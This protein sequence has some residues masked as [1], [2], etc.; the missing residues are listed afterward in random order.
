MLN[1][2]GIEPLGLFQLSIIGVPATI[3]VIIW[4]YAVGY[5]WLPDHGSQKHEKNNS[6]KS[7]QFDL[8]VPPHAGIVGKTIENAGLRE[9]KNAFLIHIQRQGN[10]IGPVGPNWPIA[11]GDILSF[12]GE[13]KAVNQ[14]A[15]AKSLKMAVPEQTDK[16]TALP[17]YEG[18][19]A[20]TSDMVGRSLKD[21]SFR[22]RIGGVVLAIQ[23]PEGHLRGALGSIPL[24][25]GDLLLIEAGQTFQYDQLVNSSHFYTISRKGVRHKVNKKQQAI[26]F[27][28]LLAMIVIA[29]SGVLPLVSV[30]LVAALLVLLNGNI[31]MSQLLNAVQLPILLVIAAA[32]GIGQAVEVSGMADMIAHALLSVSSVLGP[33]GILMVLYLT[34]NLLTELI[35]NNAAAVLMM[36]IGLSAMA[37]IDIHPHAVAMCIAIAASASFLSP[38]GY[39]TNLMV[40]GVGQYTFKDYLRAGWPLTLILMGVTVGVLYVVYG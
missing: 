27:S 38:I 13:Y 21:I 15:E 28:I 33:I 22:E 1:T 4:M 30:A 25:A 29:A 7:F 17:L 14:I 24:K 23:R 10:I 11:A 20:H 31:V 35:T 36:S 3:L 32:I 18:V 26:A 16:A 40:M 19:L 37:S 8:Y 12:S 5:K 39:Q 34:T 2:E 9:L 6:K